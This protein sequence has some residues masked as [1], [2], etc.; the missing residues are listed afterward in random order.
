MKVRQTKRHFLKYESHKRLTYSQTST[1]KLFHKFLNILVLSC[2]NI[3]YASSPHYPRYCQYNLKSK[4]NIITTTIIIIAVIIC[5]E[6]RI[7]IFFS[8]LYPLIRLFI[9][10]YPLPSL[11]PAHPSKKIFFYYL[12]LAK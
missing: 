5:V 3:V 2:E 8:L 10:E 1:F 9:Y 6:Q 7:P 4:N 11:P 12:R